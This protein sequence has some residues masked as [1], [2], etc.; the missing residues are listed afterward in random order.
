[1]GHLIQR[2]RQ[3]HL[4]L[5]ESIDTQQK[6]INTYIAFFL[7]KD[8]LYRVDNSLIELYDSKLS[9]SFNAD[10]LEAAQGSHL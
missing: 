9:E 8:I 2:S 7:I 10:K 3:Q 5:V 6:S 4:V 1:M